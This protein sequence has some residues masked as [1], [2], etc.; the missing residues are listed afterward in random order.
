MFCYR[1]S[2]LCLGTAWLAT[3]ALGQSPF[4][5]TFPTWEVE[6]AADLAVI[7]TP[8]G[9]NAD[10]DIRPE[11]VLYEIGLSL[12]TSRFLD[13]GAEIGVRSALRVQKDHPARP[14]FAG[15]LPTGQ[16]GPPAA[17]TDLQ[18]GEPISAGP[19]GRLEVAHVYLRGGYGEL[20]AGRDTGV[21]ARFQEGQTGPLRF[22]TLDAPRLDALGLGLVTTRLDPT[23]PSAKLSYTTPRLLGLQ[24]GVSYTPQ[25]EADGL[26]RASRGPDTDLSDTVEVALNLSR[27]LAGSGARLRAGAGYISGTPARGAGTVDGWSTG[28]ELD[29]GVMA[30]GVSALEADEGLAGGR[31]RAVSAGAGREFGDWEVGVRVG[32]ADSDGLGLEAESWSLSAGRELGRG[33]SI[34]GAFQS[35]RLEPSGIGQT[36][37]RFVRQ[38]D[39]AVIEITLTIG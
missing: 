18:G 5:D 39:S 1:A 16:P 14:G 28:A 12:N 4:D 33:L 26:D 2:L 30:F 38:N 11:A 10:G 27:R 17:L 13:N 24:G 15:D 25:R 35:Q 3:P 19:R 8:G 36:D 32:R 34:A 20:S 9:G 22:S 31:Y 23:G 6:T 7:A 37:A 21:A 29:L